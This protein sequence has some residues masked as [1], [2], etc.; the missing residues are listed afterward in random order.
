[1]LMMLWSQEEDGERERE[2][3]EGGSI[4]IRYK[5]KLVRHENIICTIS[6]PFNSLFMYLCIEAM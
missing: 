4:E 5:T 1:M 3:E 2:R 6:E